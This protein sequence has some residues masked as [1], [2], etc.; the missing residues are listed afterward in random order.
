MKPAISTPRAAL[1]RETG[2]AIAAQPP[3]ESRRT[4]SVRASLS[5]VCVCVCVCVL[6]LLSVFAQRDTICIAAIRGSETNQRSSDYLPGLHRCRLRRA[7]RPPAPN[8]PQHRIFESTRV[9]ENR[10]QNQTPNKIAVLWRRSHT[11]RPT[12]P[13]NLQTMDLQFEQKQTNRRKKE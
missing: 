13:S 4:S 11:T 8:T 6:M 5:V 2:R 3:V 1:R 7:S 12:F 10:N 9:N